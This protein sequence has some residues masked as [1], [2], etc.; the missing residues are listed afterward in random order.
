MGRLT[1]AQRRQLLS[2]IYRGNDD[3]LWFW[4]RRSLVHNGW[5][6][7]RPI[8][9]LWSLDSEA[10]ITPAGRAALQEDTRHE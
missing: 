7:Y 4:Q 6:A 8:S 1:E 2:V 9:A 10:F 3:H 5:L